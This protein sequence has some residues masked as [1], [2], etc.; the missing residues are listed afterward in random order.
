[1]N[2]KTQ[3][4]TGYQDVCSLEVTGPIMPHSLHA[5]T[6]LLR[7]AQKGGF[8]VSLYT[9]EPS[10][11]LNVHVAKPSESDQQVCYYKAVLHE[12]VCIFAVV[13]VLCCECTGYRQ[14]KLLLLFNTCLSCT[15]HLVH[16]TA[17]HMIS[18]ATRAETFAHKDI[19]QNANDLRSVRNCTSV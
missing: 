1:M 17:S 10:A 9:H 5:L 11:V 8:S 19:A 7:P 3:V 18:D 13:A 14:M 2:V 16:Y 4:R 15:P 12:R 6:Q